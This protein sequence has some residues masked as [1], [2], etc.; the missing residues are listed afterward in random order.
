MTLCPRLCLTLVACFCDGIPVFNPYPMGV[1]LIYTYLFLAF[2][3]L[4]GWTAN[5]H[6]IFQL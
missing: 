4:S 2:S 6:D 5:Y 3:F 1:L